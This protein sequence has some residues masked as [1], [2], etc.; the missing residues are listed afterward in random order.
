MSTVTHHLMTQTVLRNASLDDAV[1]VQTSQSALT[2]TESA[3][4]LWE[5]NH[6]CGHCP[7]KQSKHNLVENTEVPCI[8][9]ETRLPGTPAI[10]IVAIIILALLGAEPRTSGLPASILHLT[11]AS[12]PPTIIFAQCCARG[13]SQGSSKEKV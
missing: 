3:I 2:Q 11:H 10:I 13:L 4:N 6:V 5:Q 1:I 9:N 8:R 7:L 12:S